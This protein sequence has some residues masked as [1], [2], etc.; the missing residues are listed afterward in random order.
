MT[1]DTKLMVEVNRI[2]NKKC[3]TMSRILFQT[4]LSDV[5][6]LL[7]VDTDTLFLGPLE[8]IWRHFDLMNS[9]QMAALSP[10]HEDPNTGWYNRFAKHPYYGQLGEK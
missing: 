2:F 8:D 10:E 9:S 7:Y 5:D 6:A 3:K 1:L 4:V